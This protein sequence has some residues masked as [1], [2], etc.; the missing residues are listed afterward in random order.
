MARIFLCCCFYFSHGRVILKIKWDDDNDYYYFCRNS[1]ATIGTKSRILIIITY[2]H[3][4]QSGEL[5]LSYL[6]CH[7][8]LLGFHKE[9][10]RMRELEMLKVTAKYLIMPRE[11]CFPAPWCLTDLYDLG[12]Q[13]GLSGIAGSLK[14]IYAILYSFICF[15]IQQIVIKSQMCVKMN[16][17]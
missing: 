2:Q 16:Q 9:I 3:Y 1:E 7:R 14:W 4:R 12:W 6:S 13:R 10:Q 17:T 8:Y 11:D 5:H 15:S